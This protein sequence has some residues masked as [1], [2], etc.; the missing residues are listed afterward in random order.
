MPAPIITVDSGIVF[1]DKEARLVLWHSLTASIQKVNLSY[2]VY[3]EDL[4]GL[5]TVEDK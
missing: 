4:L 5:L 3:I 1:L 2:T